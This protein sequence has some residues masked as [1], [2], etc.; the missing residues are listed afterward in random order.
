MATLTLLCALLGSTL[1]TTPA[2]AAD[3]HRYLDLPL[4]N[5]FADKHGGG[6]NRALPT[7]LRT[8]RKLVDAARAGGTDPHRYAALLFQYRLVQATTE[9]ASTSPVGIR[10]RDSTPPGPP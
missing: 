8:L 4:T 10:P 6:V 3:Y 2:Q 9:A 7:D 5:R 1:V